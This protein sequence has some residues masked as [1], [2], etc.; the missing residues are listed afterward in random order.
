MKHFKFFFAI[1]LSS[2]LTGCKCCDC[3]G[4]DCNNSNSY[5]KVSLDIF[6]S[7]IDARVNP[8]IIDYRSDSLYQIGH[9]PG[10]INIP[11]SITNA[12]DWKDEDGPIMTQIKELFN[13]QEKIFLYGESGWTAV[14]I[15]LPGRVGCIWGKEYT[16]HLESGFAAWENAGYTV[17][18]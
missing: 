16:V 14:G 3:D 13:T 11:V 15:S 5:L 1:V 9:I 4:G 10:A 8:Q 17:E 6:K 2:C 7:Q 12:K 18:R